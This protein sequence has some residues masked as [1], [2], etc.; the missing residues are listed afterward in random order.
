[1]SDPQSNETGTAIALVPHN[2]PAI[3]TDPNKVDDMLGRIASAARLK[4]ADADV[5]TAKGRDTIRSAAH[6]VARSKTA[7]LDA[8]LAL[9]ESHRA[10]IKAVNAERNRIEEKL[11]DVKAEV[12]APLTKWEEDEKARV[13]ALARRLEALTL[14]DPDI[15]DSAAALAN[16][17]ARI[18][19]IAIDETWQERTAEA[20]IAKDNTLRRFRA[21][22]A[23]AVTREEQEA[24]LARLRAEAAARAAEEA[25]RE[26]ERAAAAEAERAEQERI[27]REK[28][29]AER[30]AR[31][32]E[33]KAEAARR[34]A[35]EERAAAE[36]EAAR[37][38]A[39][40]EAAAQREREAAAAALRRAEEEKAAA[41]EA[42]RQRAARERQEAE[43]AQAKRDADKKR[44]AKARGEI[45]AAVAAALK[46][47]DSRDVGFTIADALMAGEIPHCEVRL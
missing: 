4:V 40:I 9:T 37:K 25:E 14:A 38:I 36:R 7:L 30:L 31:I 18:E 24:E 3:L 39:E 34:A 16:E 11:D 42:E 44:R 27:A 20:G 29:E 21:A 19:S 10:A 1:M 22:H 13:D 45:A 12:R 17:I 46:N 47:T 6:W 26:R 28:A 8:G 35:E 43:A 32:E 5:A 2:L 41:V 33:E 15:G 23:A